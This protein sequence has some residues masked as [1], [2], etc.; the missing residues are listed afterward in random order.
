M[1]EEEK[2]IMKPFGRPKDTKAFL[3]KLNEGLDKWNKL[4]E[5]LWIIKFVL[6]IDLPRINKMDI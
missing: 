4:K 5:Q 2:G 3:S 1:N 6:L